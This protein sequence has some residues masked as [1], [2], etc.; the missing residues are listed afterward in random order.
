MRLGSRYREVAG[1]VGVEASPVY[2]WVKGWGPG[3]IPMGVLGGVV[4]SSGVVGGDE[5]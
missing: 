4:R 2:R 3:L 5:K 1:R